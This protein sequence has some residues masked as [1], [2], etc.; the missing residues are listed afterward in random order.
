MNM[1]NKTQSNVDP[2]VDFEL[3]RIE[4][5][6]EE[7]EA[8]EEQFFKLEPPADEFEFAI[9]QYFQ[10]IENLEV[11]YTLE[12]LEV[13]FINPFESE[14][15]LIQLRDE[16]LIEERQAYEE[17]FLSIADSSLVSNVL[18]DRQIAS[19]MEEEFLELNE[20]D[21]DCRYEAEEFDIEDWQYEE[22]MF[23]ELHYLREG[24][25]EKPSCSCMDLDYMPHD[26]GLCD[27]MDCYDYPEGPEENLFG[28]KFY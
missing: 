6:I 28:I 27:Y 22:N 16:K 12:D 4:K 7:R 9:K 11:D 17:D 26:D 10:D 3:L 25:F 2:V 21:Y 5:L 1:Y 20:Y 23:W 15:A 13:D 24:Q 14:D 19:R 8:Y 18:L